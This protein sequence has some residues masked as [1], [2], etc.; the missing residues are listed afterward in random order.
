MG[1]NRAAGLLREFHDDI[2]E[3]G[4]AAV[5]EQG[6]VGAINGVSDAGAQGLCLV[7][8]EHYDLI[9]AHQGDVVGLAAGEVERG[10]SSPER[11]PPGAPLAYDTL[12]LAYYED[13]P[14]LQDLLTALRSCYTQRQLPSAH[15]GEV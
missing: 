9:L 7:H 10:V 1:G 8:V 15:T 4:L 12:S 2:A 3:R 11:S 6:D 5:G 13:S 14:L